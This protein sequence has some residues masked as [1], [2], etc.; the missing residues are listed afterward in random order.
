MKIRKGFILTEDK[1]TKKMVPFFVNVRSEDVIITDKINIDDVLKQ[2]STRWGLSK[3]IDNIIETVY[4][5]SASWTSA[6][7]SLQEDIPVERF[8]GTVEYHLYKDGRLEIIGL[9][10]S[11][12]VSD[13]YHTIMPSK[14]FYCDS[15]CV[16]PFE[17]P[18]GLTEQDIS[19]TPAYLVGGGVAMSVSMSN[20][21]IT[22]YELND[23]GTNTNAYTFWVKCRMVI[24]DDPDMRDFNQ[25]LLE[26]S[27]GGS[28]SVIQ[29]SNGE[30]PWRFHY[31][32]TW[33]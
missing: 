13:S 28:A 2:T 14:G 3:V 9:C 15:V 27:Q 4:I 20:K 30:I 26:E 22:N 21:P 33:E 7:D 29:L 5:Y 24:N 10:E 19:I 31:R 18:H 17:I 16:L 1:D 12:Y 6:S 8:E 23:H 11:S 32:G 25:Y